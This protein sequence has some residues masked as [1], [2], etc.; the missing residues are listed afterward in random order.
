MPVIAGVG[1]SWWRFY[2]GQNRDHMDTL[3]SNVQEQRVKLEDIH[4]L[5]ITHKIH[6]I[7]SWTV[8][9]RAYAIASSVGV[10]HT[11]VILSPGPE[12]QPTG[13]KRETLVSSR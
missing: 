8:F 1:A 5:I 9:W 12:P 4:T 11:G 3:L 2:G 10:L 7:L 6:A 13:T